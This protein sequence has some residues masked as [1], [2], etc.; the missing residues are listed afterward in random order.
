[1]NRLGMLVSYSGV[2]AGISELALALAITMVMAPTGHTSAQML[3]PMHLWPLTMVALPFSR[4]STSPSGQASTHVPHPMQR[5]E[6]D[7]WMLCP[8]PVGKIFPC[9]A[10]SIAAFSRFLWPIQ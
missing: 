3:W 6:I 2:R 1:M 8:R 7:M 4:P 5:V 9:S 10:A